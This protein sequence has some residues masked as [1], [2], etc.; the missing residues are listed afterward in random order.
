MLHFDTSGDEIE[1]SAFD[2]DEAEWLF[3][4]ETLGWKEGLNNETANIESAN[5]FSNE[6]VT[7]VA[8]YLFLT[9][10][11]GWK[12]GLTIFK[13]EGEKAIEKELQQIQQP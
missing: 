3:L 10:Q 12:K 1:E 13:E 8:E 11:M 2:R 7:K 6:S 5:T 4:T 9:E